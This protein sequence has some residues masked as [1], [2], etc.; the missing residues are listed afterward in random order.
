[1]KPR[2]VRI[3]ELRL[4]SFDGRDAVLFVRCSSGTYI[5]SLA[6]DL[7]LA[8]GSRARLEGLERL[9]VGPFSLDEAGEAEDF[10]PEA[11]L[12][13][14]DPRLAASL[15]FRPRRLGQS[16]VS[17][18]LNGGRIPCGD[19]R[20]CEVEPIGSGMAGSPCSAV[21]SESGELLGVVEEASSELRY[22]F[23]LGEV[24]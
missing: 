16:Q 7:A 17:V 21:F 2:P 4:E 19:L 22:R 1:M 11:H 14:L 9:S 12:A 20:D 6:R 10:D 13:R 3:G 15:G 18:F 8:S 23:V 5:R 24:P